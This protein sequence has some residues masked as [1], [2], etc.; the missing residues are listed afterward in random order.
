VRRLFWIGV[1]VG[2]SV[3]GYRWFKKQ[4]KKYGPEAVA[5]KL[6]EGARDAWKL[7]G[8][9]VEEGKKAAAEKEA[10]LQASLNERG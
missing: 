10:E 8:V 2:V 1:G 6:S 3:A 9:A 7:V 4:Q 5:T